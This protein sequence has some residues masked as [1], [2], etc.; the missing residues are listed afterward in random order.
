MIRSAEE[1]NQI[2]P[3]PHHSVFGACFASQRHPKITA[4]TPEEEE[5][6][7]LP[8]SPMR[9]GSRLGKVLK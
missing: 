4:H 5:D 2:K 3:A 6:T 1:R 8:H 7:T 9:L